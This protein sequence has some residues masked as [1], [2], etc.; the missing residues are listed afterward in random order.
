MPAQA[1]SALAFLLGSWPVGIVVGF[2]SSNRTYNWSVSSTVLLIVMG[3]FVA[4]FG[5]LSFESKKFISVTNY[6]TLTQLY[7]L[8]AA[9]LGWVI[10]KESL[11]AKQLAGG[12]LLLV[13]SYLAIYSVKQSRGVHSSSLKGSILAATAGVSLGIGLVAEKASLK[14]FSMGAYFIVGYGA[15]AIVATIVAAPNINGKL[16]SSLS[17]FELI[18]SMVSGFFWCDG[19]LCIYKYAKPR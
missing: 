4:G 14:N 10:L 9:L 6:S 13:G 8:V 2:L 15:Q 19:R 12:A 7:V 16:I 17:R 5:A 18:G 3:F 1:T 11:D